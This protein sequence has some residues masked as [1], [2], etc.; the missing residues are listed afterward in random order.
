ML[1]TRVLE[2]ESPVSKMIR[3][4]GLLEQEMREEGSSLNLSLPTLRMT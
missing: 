3:E 1:R 4:E 2:K